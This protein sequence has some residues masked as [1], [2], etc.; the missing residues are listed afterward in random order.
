MGEKANY[1]TC[2]KGHKVYVIWSPQRKMFAFTCDE[3]N[4]H[5]ERAL[6]ERGLISIHVDESTRRGN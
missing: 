1:V 2:R 3:C 6:S 4:E 5:S